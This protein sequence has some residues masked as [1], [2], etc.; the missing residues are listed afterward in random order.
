MLPYLHLSGAQLYRHASWCGPTSSAGSRMPQFPRRDEVG[1]H[2]LSHL[3]LASLCWHQ[4]FLPGLAHLLWQPFKFLAPCTP[5]A[6]GKSGLLRLLAALL[7]EHED[8]GLFISPLRSMLHSFS[9]SPS[10]PLRSQVSGTGCCSSPALSASAPPLRFPPT[11][12]LS[13]YSAASPNT[14]RK[15]PVC[16]SPFTWNL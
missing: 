13:R 2:M 5:W 4:I 3:L 9:R 1:T 16:L 11:P 14:T 12:L 7:P 10:P 8:R 6:L 15:S